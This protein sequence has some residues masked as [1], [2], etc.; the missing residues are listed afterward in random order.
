MRDFIV[1]L[2]FLTALGILLAVAVFLEG[3][4]GR[5]G[6]FRITAYFD[7]IAGLR[8][9]DSVRIL[10]HEM[11]EVTG[12]S[13][14]PDKNSI[15]VS[16]ELV[17]EI[18]PGEDYTLTVMDASTLGGKFVDY[19]PGKEGKLASAE[20]LRGTATENLLT[21][22]GA[23]I[24]ENRE[25]LKS[26]LDNIRDIT[27]DLKAGKG[28]LGRMLTD[29]EMSERINNIL[30][31]FELLI[32]RT[33]QED[34][35]IYLLT[36]DA[37]VAESVK[38]SVDSFAKL[39]EEASQPDSGLRVLL[40]PD[41][42]ERVEEI[43]NNV[44]DFTT[45]LQSEEG[46]LHMVVRDPETRE[47]VETLLDRIVNGPGPLYSLLADAE[48]DEQL[49]SILANLDRAVYQ[50]AG[51]YGTIGQLL[52]SDELYQEVVKA[53]QILRDGAED[54]REQAPVSTFIQAA[55]NAFP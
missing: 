33:T 23:L 10:G 51:P 29:Q 34:N 9:G 21:E 27:A 35:L 5:E 47:K 6:T 43:V 16:L 4:A 46:V 50:L 36:N 40:S 2:V 42:G 37:E 52:Y 18:E 41:T 1:G 55:F 12:I 14:E 15:L 8:V 32:S 39:T 24:S 13:Y 48:V 28:P 54:F 7:N 25:S 26:S 3:F 17:R 20:N 38:T 30:E 11:G 19:F 22:A 44:A 53:V 45:D 49:K 31:E